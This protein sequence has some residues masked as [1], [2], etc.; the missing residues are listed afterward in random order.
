MAAVLNCHLHEGNAE[1]RLKGCLL[2]AAVLFLRL[3]GSSLLAAEGEHSGP[4]AGEKRWLQVST[5]PL[6]LPFH[7]QPVPSPLCTLISL[8]IR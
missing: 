5:P 8:L 4:P 7:P 6:T 3:A 2:L 1:H